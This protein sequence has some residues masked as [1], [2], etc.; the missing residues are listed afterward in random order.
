MLALG[1]FLALTSAVITYY[2]ASRSPAVADPVTANTQVIVAKRDIPVRTVIFADVVTA[3]QSN[4]AVVPAGALRESVE[5]L[6]RV[7]SQ[8]IA[9]IE[10]FHVIRLHAQ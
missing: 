9:V 3:V 1:V 5:A 7:A 6:I 8:L 10:V 4:F 2:F